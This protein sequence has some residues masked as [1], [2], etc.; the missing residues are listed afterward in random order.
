MNK[1][2]SPPAYVQFR[3]M[4]S[5]KNRRTTTDEISGET[6]SPENSS[7]SSAVNNIASNSDLLRQVLLC[8]PVKS[9][10]IFKSVSKQWLSIISDPHFIHNHC[11]R[12]CSLPIP[13]LLLS[14]PWS[15]INPEFEFVFLDEKPMGI[16][17]YKTLPFAK[18]SIDIK[19]LQ[20]CNGL[21]CCS[22]S[23][24]SAGK[25]T[26]YYIY[27]PS[28]NHYNI[29][30]RSKFQERGSYYVCSVSLA[31]DPLK[32]PYYEVV[33]IGWVYRKPIHPNI[34]ETV[35]YQIEMYSSKSASWSVS[36]NISVVPNDTLS[37]S[38]VFWNGSLHWISTSIESSLCFDINRELVKPMPLPS[39]SL[40]PDGRD[41][42]IGYF[43]ECKGHMHLT[44]GCGPFMSTHFNVLE[45]EVD[46]TGW[47]V[48]Y[49]V[50]LDTFAVAYPEVSRYADMQ[51]WDLS[52][53]RYEFYVLL[54]EEDEESPK[55]VLMTPDKVISYNL[56]DMSF[57][58]IHDLAPIIHEEN[59][60]IRP[61]ENSTWYLWRSNAYQY[62]E[63][64]ACV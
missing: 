34:N 17:P 48:K 61:G 46:Y 22:S 51:V 53:Y 21:F 1:S 56:K 5:C 18:D 41:R 8:L 11:F 55:L 16:V 19:I 13:G 37:R 59:S 4:L 10:F 43:G 52:P 27:N 50:V 26:T 40:I 2:S 20:S 28:T 45:M 9:L 58:K 33:L 32:S 63:T 15:S 39:Q 25:S 24:L 31:F 38:G 47:N 14:K 54:V 7:S 60:T 6:N 64:L 62:I 57:K 35:N 42:R 44:V 49:R 29:L 30:P 3:M 12:N 36:R 23:N